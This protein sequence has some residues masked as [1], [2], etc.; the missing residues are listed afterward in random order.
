M[1]D[2]STR[3]I[4]R[5]DLQN[6]WPILPLYGWPCRFPEVGRGYPHNLW[7][8]DPLS[9]RGESVS[10]RTENPLPDP[11]TV[12]NVSFLSFLGT[13]SLAEERVS[14]AGQRTPSRAPKQ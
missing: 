1:T 13:R 8:G 5:L 7:F 2:L 12:K 14:L 9:G 11:K 3:N 10:G 6:Y 4:N